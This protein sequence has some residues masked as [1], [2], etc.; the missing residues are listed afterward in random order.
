MKKILLGVLASLLMLVTVLAV[1]YLPLIFPNKSISAASVQEE[2]SAVRATNFS[3]KLAINQLSLDEVT[4]TVKE[5]G[6]QN[7]I[8]S[9]SSNINCYIAYPQ[10]MTETIDK[11]VK[12]WAETQQSYLLEKLSAYE[13]DTLTEIHIDYSSYFTPGK[14]A[15]IQ[16]VGYYASTRYP[17]I[18]D[19]VHV[20]NFD[21][22]EGKLLKV[23]DIIPYENQEKVLEL[24]NKKLVET[25][26]DQKI[27]FLAVDQSWLKN[28]SLTNDG[29]E[30]L[31]ERG[32][33]LP[34]I[35]GIQKIKI[36][37]EDLE[38]L[39]EIPNSQFYIDP[40]KPMIA[41][42][43]DDGPSK[44]TP[45]ILDI[46]EQNDARATFFVLGHKV[47]S[48]TETLKRI[49][50]MGCEIGNH[51]WDHPSFK[52]LNY[53]KISKQISSTNE[54]VK[55]VTDLKPTLMRPPYGAYNDTAIKALKEQ[56][57]SII[58]WSVDTLDWKSRNADAVYNLTMSSV[59]DGA[60]IL[61]HDLYPSTKAA[62]E[63]IIPELKS[64][65][66]QLV[67]VSE[68]MSF[69]KEGGLVSGNIYT[70]QDK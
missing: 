49:Q 59:K 61:F 68:L 1:L 12:S 53:E 67:T 18:E 11:H 26:P 64:Q 27:R 13:N 10:E 17:E 29:I 54:K 30:F 2:D 41:L 16:Q 60:I 66:Y 37:Y 23:S 48:K 7:Q 14:F 50:E 6:V 45:E 35:R 9:Y 63:K 43:F 36:L 70:N 20:F 25:F 38:D 65:G 19:V 57:M 55:N 32:K 5:Y 62:V 69:N 44:I 4:N 22:K 24:L 15:S 3:N 34:E 31:F 46:L 21:L 58:L 42:T 8:E 56:G 33:A 40:E 52:K 39:V 51:S 28:L 47:E